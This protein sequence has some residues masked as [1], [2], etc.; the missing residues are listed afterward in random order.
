MNE[1]MEYIA[2]LEDPL[3]CPDCSY[4]GEKPPNLARHVA[5]VHSKLDEML[6]NPDLVAKRKKEHMSKPS[7]IN[8]GSEC[9]VW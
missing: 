3:Q 6:G 4:K 9:P 8:I 7:K 5:L 1:L 2:S